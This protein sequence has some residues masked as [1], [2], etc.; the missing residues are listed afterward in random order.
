M[1]RVT[2]KDLKE[3]IREIEEIVGKL[4]KDD[5]EDLRNTIGEFGI[6]QYNKGCNFAKRSKTE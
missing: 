3:V 6:A 1:I 5:K 4:D 2:L